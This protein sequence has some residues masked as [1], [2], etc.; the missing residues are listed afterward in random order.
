MLLC[1]SCFLPVTTENWWGWRDLNPHFAKKL[2][3]ETSASTNSAT[4]PK[5]KVP[6]DDSGPVTWRPLA[7]IGTFYGKQFVRGFAAVTDSS[8][9]T[10]T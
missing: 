10:G 2:V 1:G 6:V 3:L 5:E 8:S 7:L 4:A 9:A